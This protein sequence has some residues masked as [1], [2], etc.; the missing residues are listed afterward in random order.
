MAF[1]HLLT[2]SERGRAQKF[3][4]RD[5]QNRYLCVRGAL[6]RMLSQYCSRSPTAIEL[7]GNEFGKPRLV[8]PPIDIRFN[9][10]H[11][12]GV[13]LIGIALGR[14]IGV[15]VEFHRPGLVREPIAERFFCPHEVRKLRSLPD[16][17]QEAAFFTCW[18]RKEAYTK[19]IGRGLG[20]SLDQFEV[21]LLIDE[22]PK[23]VADALDPGQIGRWQFFSVDCGPGY[24]AAVAVEGKNIRM[25]Q[26]EFS[27]FQID[28][29]DE[30]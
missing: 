12:H 16:G 28:A 30:S 4:R 2:E 23:L 19:A 11:S 18:T 13:G 7:T 8:D 9:V 5:D 10:S 17:E 20:L 25:T 15:D 6:R 14:E 27:D 21:T 29:G 1:R 22:P 24:S 3:L 26:H